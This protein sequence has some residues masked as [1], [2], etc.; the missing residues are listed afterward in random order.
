MKYIKYLVIVILLLIPLNVFAKSVVYSSGYSF[1]YLDQKLGRIK[2]ATFELQ[3]ISGEKITDITADLSG[4]YDILYRLYSVDYEELEDS[5]L[6]LIFDEEHREIIKEL[7]SNNK[8]R[9]IEEFNEYISTIETDEIIQL[10]I[11]SPPGLDGWGIV[12]NTPVRMVEKNSEYPICL[13]NNVYFRIIFELNETKLSISMLG[14][15]YY[16]DKTDDIS[17]IHN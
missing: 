1:G 10:A 4:E 14:E 3:N 11:T 8:Y 9:N 12:G 17:Q 2:N 16:I 5:D 13:Y 6:F 15:P 7:L